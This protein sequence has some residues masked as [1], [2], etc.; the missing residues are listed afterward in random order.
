MTD[1]ALCFGGAGFSPCGAGFS[2]QRGL[3]P[4]LRIFPFQPH[5]LGMELPRRR[6]PH[7]HPETAWLFVTW[8]LYGSLPECRY[9]PPDHS[10]AGKAFVWMDRYLDTTRTGPMWLFTNP[11]TTERRGGVNENGEGAAAP[12]ALKLEN[13]ASLV[14][15][16]IRNGAGQDGLYELRAWVIMANHVHLL[17]RPRIQPSEMLRKLKGRT[18]REANLLLGR[19]GKPFWQPESYDRWMRDENEIAK[20]FGTSK[21]IQ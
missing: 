4:P 13:I 15:A 11:R 9:P 14:A 5:S 7:W 21:T 10:S 17:V 20:R 2:L 6:L 19:T 12:C 3:Q 18:A 16:H 8:H 1:V